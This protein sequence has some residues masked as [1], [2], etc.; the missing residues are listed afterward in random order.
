MLRVNSNSTEDVPCALILFA[1]TVAATVQ[2]T[3]GM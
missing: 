2:V 1:K 3:I